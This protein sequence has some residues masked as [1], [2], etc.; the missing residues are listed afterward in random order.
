MD[1]LARHLMHQD[2]DV[3]KQRQAI[4]SREEV[5]VA[6]SALLVMYQ[7]R[8]MYISTQEES[9]GSLTHDE[10]MRYGHRLVDI[11]MHFFG[12]LI[13]CLRVVLQESRV[14]CC[15]QVRGE[16]RPVV[17]LI[18]HVV[19]CRASVR[20]SVGSEDK[21]AEAEGTTP[22]KSSGKSS[23]NPQAHSPFGHFHSFTSA[24]R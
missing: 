20:C 24:P 9:E 19:K 22:R 10:K 3:G 12:F 18:I 16:K 6:G 14:K 8:W 13:R 11:C 5:C 4:W 7:A 15:D 21:G 23:A 2:M 1:V 17:R